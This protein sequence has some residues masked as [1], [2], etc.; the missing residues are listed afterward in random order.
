[1]RLSDANSVASRLQE[2]ISAVQGEIVGEIPQS[3]EEALAAIVPPRADAPS[4]AELF[5]KSRARQKLKDAVKAVNAGLTAFFA[6]LLGCLFTLWF[7]GALGGPFAD[8]SPES[9]INVVY[10]SLL[11]VFLFVGRYIV[12]VKHL[13][14]LHVFWL[15]GLIFCILQIAASF[16]AAPIYYSLIRNRPNEFS[17]LLLLARSVYN[18]DAALQFAVGVAGLLL[19]VVK[20]NS[21][22]RGEP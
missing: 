13:K 17:S 18:I 21:Y 1:M 14:G 2:R 12:R 19:I 6:L 22:R 15:F 20:W 16:A 3:E 4:P 11:L 8:Q 5:E 7:A 10:F 9:R